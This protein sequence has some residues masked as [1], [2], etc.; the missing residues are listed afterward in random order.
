MVF[1]FVLPTR[2]KWNKVVLALFRYICLIVTKTI[3]QS[4]VKF[5]YLYYLLSICVH[6]HTIYFFFISIFFLPFYFP[7]QYYQKM[8]RYG[9]MSTGV[10]RA[11]K[12]HLQVKQFHRHRQLK[13]LSYMNRFDSFI[14]SCCHKIFL[15]CQSTALQLYQ[16]KAAVLFL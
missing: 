12:L 10:H 8:D 6:Q 2:R 16:M 9:G 13:C 11:Y 1:L 15:F 3:V 4:K 5:I 14:D 7:A